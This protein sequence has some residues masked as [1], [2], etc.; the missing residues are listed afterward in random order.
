MKNLIFLALVLCFTA[1]SE[2]VNDNKN[3]RDFFELPDSENNSD[4]LTETFDESR[5]YATVSKG[6]YVFVATELD[7]ILV[8]SSTQNDIS[9]PVSV[10]EINARTLLIVDNILYA[11]G[12]GAVYSVDVSDP[13]TPIVIS[14]QK[15]EGE[16]IE[17]KINE[18][19]LYAA[20]LD[21]VNV[22]DISDKKQPV[23]TAVH[24]F[25]SVYGKFH[26]SGNNFILLENSG[27]SFFLK[28]LKITSGS[29]NEISSLEIPEE[30]DYIN[31]S[32]AWFSVYENYIYLFLI[33][34]TTAARAPGVIS[35]VYDISD[36]SNP[37]FKSEMM[38][39]APIDIKESGGEVFFLYPDYYFNDVEEGVFEMDMTDPQK[40]VA[41]P[42]YKGTDISAI[43]DLRFTT[44]D[45]EGLRLY[46]L[47]EEGSQMLDHQDILASAMNVDVIGDK[48]F[49]RTIEG[50]ILVVDL[51]NTSDLKLADGEFTVSIIPEEEFYA[52]Y[53]GKVFSCDRSSKS[54]IP[55]VI[56]YGFSDDGT[57]DSERMTV[58]T[59]GA[60]IY[61]DFQVDGDLLMI[62]PESNE[63]RAPVIADISQEEPSV[64]DNSSVTVGKYYALK[65]NRF[66]SADDSML[67]LYDL[68]KENGI[69]KTSEK[70]VESSTGMIFLNEE[71]LYTI[72]ENGLK[73]FEIVSG[74]LTEKKDVEITWTSDILQDTKI[75]TKIVNGKLLISNGS[76]L[77][78]F[79]TESIL[80]PV[81]MASLEI[82]GT[83]NDFTLYQNIVIVAVGENGLLFYKVF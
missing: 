63:N 28:I 18:K 54:A 82:N 48:A 36:L 81:L 30:I 66:A 50:R 53:N 80:E 6:E 47:T 79:N 34:V 29:M 31:Y 40:P 52:F 56:A 44:H 12:T 13:S 68:S 60:R 77:K 61:R 72:N 15:A 58:S 10:I 23:R 64:Y 35:F 41:G 16:I 55:D 26:I 69:T 8:L 43:N 17:I 22:F 4:D 75:K 7:G 20:S 83:I 65:E 33:E 39:H 11:G 59:S 78:I 25:D 49:V 3:D 71:V 27:N 1:C 19:E 37:V 42:E 70:K 62:V 9:D 21:K 45:T 76:T 14:T 67:K 46:S 32:P 73:V 74:E 38:I 2:P 24:E 5:M 57:F 51:K